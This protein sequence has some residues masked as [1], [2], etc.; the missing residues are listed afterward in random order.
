MR[1]IAVL[2]RQDRRAFEARRAPR[3]VPRE[4][5]PRGDGT[6]HLT[7]LLRIKAFFLFLTL[8]TENL[9]EK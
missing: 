9:S 2:S 3:N 7:K 4:L 6:S 5:A 1:F 8:H